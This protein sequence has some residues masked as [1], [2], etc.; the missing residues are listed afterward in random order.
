MHCVTAKHILSAGNGMNLYRGCQHG[1]IYCDARSLC[2][3]MNHV[4]EDIEVKINAN[5][6]V[7]AIFPAQPKNAYD[8]LLEMQLPL[9]DGSYM[10]VTDYGSA[11]KLWND[12]SKMAVWMLTKE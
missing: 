8:C 6:T 9:T 12:E 3:Q 7:D 4:F 11:G 2:Y 10:T 5:E 1:C